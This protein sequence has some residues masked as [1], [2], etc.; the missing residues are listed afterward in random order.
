MTQKIIF[1]LHLRPSILERVNLLDTLWSSLRIV[2]LSAGLI[3]D[4]KA[5]LR[6]YIDLQSLQEALI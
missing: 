5:A 3:P 6:A 1:W 2:A 4:Q